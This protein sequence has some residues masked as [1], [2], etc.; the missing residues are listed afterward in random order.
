MISYLILSYLRTLA[1]AWS[2]AAAEMEAEAEVH[3]QLAQSLSEELY[4]PIKTLADTQHKTR[5][6]VRSC[7]I[8]QPLI[9]WRGLCRNLSPVYFLPALTT[10]LLLP[11]Y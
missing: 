1:D 7:A 3:R 11:I 9:D 5:K 6:P 2:L 8:P 10:S 4:K